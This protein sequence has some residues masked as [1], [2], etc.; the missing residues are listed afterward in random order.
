MSNQN[1]NMTQG[2]PGKLLMAFA[3]PLMAGNV[4][5][6]LYT[7]VDIAIVGRGVGM[8]ALAALGTVDWMNWMYLGIAQGLT[9]GFSVRMAQKFGQADGPGLRRTLGNAAYVATII[10]IITAVVGQAALGLFLKLLQVPPELLPQAELYSRVI[11]LGI[12]A[13]MFYNFTA[14]VLRSVGDSRTPLTAMIIAAI[15][16]IVLDCV[17]V[18][19]LDWG[20]AGAAAATVLAQILAGVILHSQNRKNTAAA[21]WTG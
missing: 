3:L 18:F 9:Q 14:S 17:A 15:T 21:L 6:Q 4:F 16:N 20:I 7:V 2:H 13:M 19:L 1:L 8:D 5:Q 10:G 11:L 12:P